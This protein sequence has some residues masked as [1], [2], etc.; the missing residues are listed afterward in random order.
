MN[1]YKIEDEII[2]AVDDDP[3]NLKLIYK[4]LRGAGYNNVDLI[5]D[6]REVLAS[7]Q[8]QRPDLVLLDINMPHLDG[9]QV[10]EQL[11]AL[12]DPLLPPI[13]IL[14]AQHT[15]EF[16]IRA[17]ANG[18]RD[19]I[20]KP[21]DRS[22]LLMRVRNLIEAHLGKKILYGQKAVL[23]EMVR[24]KTQELHESRLQIVRKLGQAAEY[25][26]QET[27]NHI[28][29]MSQIAALIAKQIGWDSQACDLLLNA[30][31]MH[32]IGKIGIP[33]SVLLKPGKLGNEEWK[34]MQTH[35]DIGASLLDS[36]SSDLLIMAK[37]I[38]YAH[39][40]KWDGSGYPQGL[41]GEDIP[42]AARISAIADV[43]DALTSKRPYKDA[44][45]VDAAI[46]FLLSQKGR[47]FDPN[48]IDAFMQ[49][50]PQVQ[51]IC[52]EYADN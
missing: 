29:R 4:I 24:L 14:T 37:E 41:K 12:Q 30:S 13:I 44:W 10:M 22:E 1:D 50:L 11:C 2:L 49:V 23:E 5:S 18:A 47:Q 17:L 9:Y 25:R 32:D 7:Y 6:P 3:T 46:E 40:E 35:A 39:H 38:A 16:E 26:D 52:A 28:I 8:R 15:L 31:P 21:F 43:F 19:F 33:D 34:I 51:Q 48:L 45:P 36:D 42:V 20:S 27:G